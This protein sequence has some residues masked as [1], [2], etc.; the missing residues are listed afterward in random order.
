MLKKIVFAFL[1]V[2]LFVVNDQI[3]S[4]N[5]DTSINDGFKSRVMPLPEGVSI[6]QL[7]SGMEVLLIENPVLPMTGVNVAVK[8]GSAYETFSTSGMSH[9]LEHL[10]FNGT[11]GRSQ[12]EL[13]DEV[14]LIGGYNNAHTSAY[15]TNYMMVTPAEN[16]TKGMEL[17][18]DMLFNSTLPEDKF[19]KEKGIVLEEISKSLANPQEQFERNTSSVLYKGHALSLP[20][21]GTYSTIESLSRD[22]V[23]SFYKNNYV[24]NNM[25]LTAIGN[26]ETDEM[27]KQIKEI[28]GKAAPGLVKAEK[29]FNWNTGFQL[30]Q[31]IIQKDIVYNRF[32]DGKDN[33][34]QLF[35]EIPSNKSPGFYELLNLVF[36]KNSSEIQQSLKT[37]F[38]Q[39][40]KSFKVSTRLTPVRNFIEAVILF[41]NDTDLTE[42][43]KSTTNKLA[44]LNYMLPDETIESIETKGRTDFLKNIEKPH[45]F[46]IYNSQQIVTSGFESILSSYSKGK[47]N[48]AVKE[49]AEFKFTEQPV[50]II[51]TPFNKSDEEKT[52]STK[53]IKLYTD[54][55]AGKTLIVSQNELSNLLAIHYLVKHKAYYENKYGNDAAKILHECFGQRLNSD[56]NQKAS[57][58]F[59][60]TFT[61]NDNPFIPMDNIYLHPDFGYIRVEGL[62]DDLEGAI[63]FLNEQ[64][65]SFIPTEEEYEKATEKFKSIEMMT[66]GGDKAKQLFEETYKEIINEPNPYSDPGVDLTY[67]NLVS[68]AKEY[69]QP[70]NMIISVVSP[71]NPG[72]LNELFNGLNFVQRDVELGVYT[73]SYKLQDEPVSIEKEGGG[74][75]AYIFW[76]FTNEID[77]ADAPALKALSL[78]LS[79]NIIFDIREKQGM[80]YHMSAGINVID[81]KALFYI[82]QGTR[83]Q[84]VDILVSQYEKFFSASVIEN[85]TGEE[86]EKSVNMYLG[87]M[88]FRR[89]SSINKAYYLGS[90][91]YFENDFNRDNEFLAKLKNVKLP[92]V[93]NAAAKYMKINNPVLVIVR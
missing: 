49:L 9:M 13:Y 24:P 27:L 71:A 46:G 38:P 6:H 63:N 14:D 29:Y 20:T 5:Y 8:I 64:L 53:E 87:R 39:T 4:Q 93:K 44:S 37:E 15:Y 75:R 18:A 31:H 21:L 19:E 59:G 54:E 89:L 3:L 68:F 50:I 48:D 77:P 73:T 78:I 69:F 11:T 26:F 34:L 88:M 56:E 35:Y 76:G 32:Y 84:N 16:I 61:V 51:Q 83:P 85:L 36:E 52:E 30:P 65:N 81:N 70:S 82:N 67:E 42:L 62:A 92:D 28:Y 66:M 80:A 41:E 91:F 55:T 86:L 58:Q 72:K 57:N 22:D 12:K 40:V 2:L 17:Q 10:L 43:V 79:D 90:S 45:M 7:N 60:F 23:Y 74:E 47:Y 33:A 25:I 1:S